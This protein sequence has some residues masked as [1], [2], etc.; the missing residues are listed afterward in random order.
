[1]LFIEQFGTVIMGHVEAYVTLVHTVLMLYRFED[2]SPSGSNMVLPP[3]VML[4]L[5]IHHDELH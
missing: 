3:Y 1:M 4:L 5:C 2:A